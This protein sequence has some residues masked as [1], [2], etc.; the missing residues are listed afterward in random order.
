MQKF[1]MTL[2][3]EKALR[4]ELQQDSI[5][6]DANGINDAAGVWRKASGR[7]QLPANT[8][9]A[10]NHQHAQFSDSVT[11]GDEVAFFPQITGG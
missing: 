1:P 6:I 10:I 11:D 4:E 9:C 3:G 8:F 2:E 7:E 5:E